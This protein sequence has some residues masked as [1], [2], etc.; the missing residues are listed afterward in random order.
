MITI[1]TIIV[2]CFQ[3]TTIDVYQTIVNIGYLIVPV[4]EL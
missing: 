3:S 4:V 2:Q 1:N